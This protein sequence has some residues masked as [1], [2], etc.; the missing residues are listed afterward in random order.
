M[1][2][3]MLRSVY[4][5]RILLIVPAVLIA[6]A[7]AYLLLRGGS[8]GAEAITDGFELLRRSDQ[9]MAGIGS[10]R[11]LVTVYPPPPA[12]PGAPGEWPESYSKDLIDG[13][14]VS[15]DRTSDGCSCDAAQQDW[16]YTDRLSSGGLLLAG[17]GVA[18][19]PPQNARIVGVGLIEKRPMWVLDYDIEA[20]R[21]S[22]PYTVRRREWID[23]ENF[24]LR[25]QEERERDD[26]DAQTVRADLS[27]FNRIAGCG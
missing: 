24:L 21:D 8:E 2:D 19:S 7:G 23:K 15:S 10:L 1:A 14:C 9:A 12:F 20:E 4:H 27:L 5:V 26:R 16:P 11:V 18:T 13:R 3:A 6:V 22:G 17:P 25:R